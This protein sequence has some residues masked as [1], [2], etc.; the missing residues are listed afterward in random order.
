MSLES[1][2]KYITY[3][4]LTKEGLLSLGPVVEHM[5]EAEQLVGHKLAVS[6][7]LEAIKQTK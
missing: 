5:A 7:R 2:L 4:E 3:Q 1:F 6:I